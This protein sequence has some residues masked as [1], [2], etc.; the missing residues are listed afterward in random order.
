MKQDKIYALQVAV[1]EYNQRGW[2][3]EKIW[4]EKPTLAELAG[5]PLEEMSEKSI[6]EIVEL[7]KG[8]EIEIGTD[9]TK[10]LVKINTDG[11]V[12]YKF[13]NE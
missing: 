4:C 12:P 2:Y 3:T 7:F 10:R 5:C 9:F 1:N 8:K 13:N 11:T 6:I